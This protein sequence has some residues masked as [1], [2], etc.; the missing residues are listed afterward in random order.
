LELAAVVKEEEEDYGER[1]YS[2]D[3]LLDDMGLGD[4]ERDPW[5]DWRDWGTDM[6]AERADIKTE[7]FP[8]KLSGEMSGQKNW[9]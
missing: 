4:S 6:A 3:D 9:E 8:S 2:R 7:V 5:G 1:H